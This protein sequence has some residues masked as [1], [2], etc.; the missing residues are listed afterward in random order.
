M[1][2]LRKALLAASAGVLS[3]GTASAAVVC[4]ED[5]DCWR[6][7]GKPTYGPELRLRIHPDDWRWSPGEP[8]R[9]RE[10]GAGR[11]YYRGGV[12]VPIE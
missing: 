7:E 9:W 6:V 3:A 4:N 5:G 2:T 10:P 12:W 1:R 8:Y 11:G